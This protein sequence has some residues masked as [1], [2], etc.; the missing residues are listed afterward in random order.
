MDKEKQIDIVSKYHQKEN[1]ANTLYLKQ[2][3]FD[4]SNPFEVANCVINLGY[5]KINENE[6]VISKE[7]YRTLKLKRKNAMA[8]ETARKVCE[9]IENDNKKIRKE[10]AEKIFKHIGNHLKRYVHI[11]KYAENANKTKEEYADGTPVEL[12]SVWEVITLHKNGYDTYEKMCELQD[13]IGYIQKSRLLQ[14]FEKDFRIY[15]KQFGVEI[16]EEK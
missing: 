1:L 16:G 3:E 6:V 12:N 9:H 13:N 2:D 7:E 14:E 8:M 5:R 4:L 11:H 15:A 10:T